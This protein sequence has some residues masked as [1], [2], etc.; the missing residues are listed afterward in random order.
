MGETE[1][2]HIHIGMP[3]VAAPLTR[4][5]LPSGCITQVRFLVDRASIV[6]NGVT[7]PVKVPSGAQVGLKIVPED[8][9]TPFPIRPGDTTAIRLDY[10]AQ[11]QLVFTGSG[12]V[13]E[14]PVMRAHEVPRDFAVW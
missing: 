6:V 11:H 4:L 2:V 10:D 12:A 1:D 14:K 3:G 5:A 7:Q 13:L 9:S 8:E